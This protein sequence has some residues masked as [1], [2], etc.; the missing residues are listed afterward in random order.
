MEEEWRSIKGYSGYEVSNL[1]NVR[2]CLNTG[3]K[4][5]NKWR[6]LSPRLDN[7][8]YLFVNLYDENHNMKSIKIHRLVAME[9]IPNPNGYPQINHKDENKLNNKKNNLEWCDAKY[10]VNYGSGHTRSCLSR[11]VCNTKAILQYD[12]DGN[13]LREFYSISEASRVLDISMGSILDCL[14]R[15]TNKSREFIFRYKDNLG[16]QI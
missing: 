5:T 6:I 13:L 9:F 14:K 8:G 15:R 7:R 1:G 3:H 12:L 2:S 10:N 4:K 11:R 16:Q